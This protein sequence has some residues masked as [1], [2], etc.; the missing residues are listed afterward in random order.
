MLARQHCS[1]D[2]DTEAGIVVMSGNGESEPPAGTIL[3]AM[4]SDPVAL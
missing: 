4:L 3:N 1:P 2:P